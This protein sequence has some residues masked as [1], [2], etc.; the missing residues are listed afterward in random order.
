M[1]ISNFSENERMQIDDICK[2]GLQ[3]L[4]AD[5]VA[6]YARWTSANELDQA[7]FQAQMQTIAQTNLLLQQNAQALYNTAIASLEAQRDA[8]IAWYESVIGGGNVG[9][10][11]QPL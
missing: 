10:E 3:N 6:L 4:T 5:E 9:E 8:A 7:E 2:R 1:H 11:S